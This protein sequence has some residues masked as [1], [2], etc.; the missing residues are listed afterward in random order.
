MS[1][2][3]KQN[4]SPVGIA[5]SAALK[6]ARALLDRYEPEGKAG[7]PL[8]APSQG[9]ARRLLSCVRSLLAL[10]ESSPKVVHQEAPILTR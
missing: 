10:V 7:A 6:E 9:E 2:D 1:T 5:G 8:H 3:K 4:D